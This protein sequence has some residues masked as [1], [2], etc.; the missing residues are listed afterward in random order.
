MST[1]IEINTLNQRFGAPGRIVFRTGACGLPVVAVACRFGAC[2]IALYGAHVLSY[3]PLGH[4]PVLFMSEHARFERG[5]PIRG[6]I[7]VCWPWFGPADDAELPQHGFARIMPWIVHSTEYTAD[8]SEITLTLCD[9]DDTRRFWPYAFNLSM[10]LRIG[11]S[12]NLELTTQNRDARPFTL[13]QA[14]HPYLRVRQIMDVSIRGLDGATYHDMLTGQSG[15]QQG[16]VNIR[17]ETDRIFAPLSPQCV[18]NDPGISRTLAVVSTGANRLVVWNPWIDKARTLPDF[19]DDEYTRMLCIEPA[20]TDN[21]AVTLRPDET[22]TL[23]L[24]L[25]AVL[26]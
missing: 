3:R 24:A 14:L 5:Q 12:L 9:T 25:Q 16:L 17:G 15:V 26:T 11:P 6:G 8:S 7:P 4:L 2:E 13:T 19:G 1:S 10:R 20:N 23:S 22:H 18:L 21:D